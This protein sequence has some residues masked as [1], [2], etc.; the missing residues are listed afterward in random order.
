MPADINGITEADFQVWKHHPVS[1]IYLRYLA[2]FRA[3]LLKELLGQ[4]ENG[5]LTLD[6]EKEIRGRTLTL[7]DLTEL[8]F[9]S[10]QKFYQTEEDDEGTTAQVIA[11][12]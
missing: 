8:Q 12:T 4:W 11:E 3:M 7:A 1:K 6:T 2:D 9:A 10:I 5:K